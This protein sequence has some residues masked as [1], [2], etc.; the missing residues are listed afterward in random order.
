M[1]DEVMIR[2]SHVKGAWVRTRD[3]D[4]DVVAFNCYNICYEKIEHDCHPA[5]LA[6]LGYLTDTMP[7]A[8]T[9]KKNSSSDPPRT[10]CGSV[11][12]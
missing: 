5:M 10:M 6:I 11:I 9:L 8:S 7:E 4:G 2:G 3:N 12:K 1:Q